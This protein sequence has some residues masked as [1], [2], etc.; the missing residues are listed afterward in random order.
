MSN[1]SS[2][3]SGFFQDP[4][5][6]SAMVLA[7][8]QVVAPVVK[9]QALT[10]DEMM[11]GG[12]VRV[13]FFILDASPSMEPVAVDL[14]DGFNQH[15]VPAVLDARE[16]DVEALRVGGCAFSSGPITPIWGIANGDHF[17]QLEQLPPLTRAEYDPER[18][19][20]TDLHQAILDGS[21]VA[22]RHAA[23][24]QQ[25]TGVDV[26]V[27]IIILSDGKNNG[28]PHD[29]AVVKQL[30]TGRD[31][32]RVRYVYFY[33]DTSGGYVNFDP[34]DYAVRELGIDSEMVQT[35]GEKPGETKE[36]RA[37][38]FRRLMQVMSRVSAAR[39]T[40]AVVATAAVLE[41]EDIV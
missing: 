18:G 35:F 14:V 38:R 2:E 29:P 8:Q 4:D 25:E 31:V 7:A 11:L 12:G 23:E 27:D 32:T 21:A 30:I 40:S 13:V 9:G 28:P 24:L 1:V 22:M 16:N 3:I 34:Q 6:S 36:E 19:Y 5:A 15:F 26:N 17:H 37:K 20:G 33:F 10:M 41:D 39:N